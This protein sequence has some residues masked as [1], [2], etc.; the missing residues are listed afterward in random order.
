[1]LLIKLFLIKVS[2][3]FL[4]TLT[5]MSC[6]LRSDFIESITSMA[7]SDS[8]NEISN[9]NKISS[10]SFSFNS[11]SLKLLAALEN[12]VRKFSNILLTLIV[13]QYVML[14]Q[15]DSFLVFL[16]PN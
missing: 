1:M 7:T 15:G 9:W 2:I 3:S 6:F 16:V 14:V 10:M 13:F 4:S 5:P 11:F 8:I 12:A